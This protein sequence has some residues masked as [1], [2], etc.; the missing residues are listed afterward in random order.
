M[1]LHNN[2]TYNLVSLPLSTRVIGC[3]CIYRDSGDLKYKARLGAKGY[4]QKIGVEFYD[5]FV[6]VV[7]HFHLHSFTLVAHFDM[8]F[9]QLDVKTAFLYGD[10][11]EDIYL[12]QSEGFIDSGRPSHVCNL[13]NFFLV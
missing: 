2:H 13:T 4:I 9:E 6:P 5:I 10:L 1:S 7:S 12:Q 8:E 3:K 11:E